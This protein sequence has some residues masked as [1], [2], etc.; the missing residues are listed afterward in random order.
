MSAISLMLERVRSWFNPPPAVLLAP[1]TSLLSIEGFVPEG[2]KHG[3]EFL[4]DDKTPMVFVVWIL[5][6]EL[7]FDTQAARRLMLQIHTR[8]GALVAL[9]TPKEAEQIASAITLHA[10]NR[11]HPLSCKSIRVPEK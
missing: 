8:G 5:Q 11:G 7:G 10:K 2:F 9:N 3:I 1:G 6:K 4:N